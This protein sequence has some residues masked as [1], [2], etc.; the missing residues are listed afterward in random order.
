VEKFKLMLVKGV[1]GNCIYLNDYRI[2]GPKPWGGGRIIK[3]WKV[4]KEDIER[5]ISNYK[6]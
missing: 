4:E 6:G 1:E 2:C 3:T 5:A